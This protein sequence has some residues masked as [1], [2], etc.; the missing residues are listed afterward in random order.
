MD[1]NLIAMCGEYINTL[2]FPIFACIALAIFLYRKDREDR[3][4]R[5][6]TRQENAKER[7]EFLKTNQKLSDS[8][9][10]LQS[11]IKKDISDVKNDVND[12]KK[13]IETKQA[14]IK[15]H[16]VP[17]PECAYACN[18]SIF[19]VQAPVFSGIRLSNI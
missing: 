2:G 15:L 19:V 18:Q 5:L 9:K 13:D 10:F 17:C 3:E 14:E 4:D 12:L 6:L 8:I 16:T 11:D 7:R 1:T